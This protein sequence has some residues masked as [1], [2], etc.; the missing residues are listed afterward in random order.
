MVRDQILSRGIRDD[1]VLAAMR[2]VPR[3]RFVPAEYV[4]SAYD[5]CALAIEHLQT[6]S[7][8]FIVAYMTNA[9]RVERNHKVLEIGMGSGY[10]TAILAHFTDQL[11]TVERIEALAKVAC[12]RLAALGIPLPHIRTGDGSVGWPEDAPYDRIIVTAA[13]PAVPLA[14]LD[15][16]VDGGRMVIPVGGAERQRLVSVW[17][18][19][20]CTLERPM[21]PCRFVKLIGEGGW[22]A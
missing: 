16:L 21:I 14:L 6:I 20:G 18:R 7:Q 5:D 11:Y 4:E 17:K 13:A 3:E 19:R 9:L 15:Q 1:R 8:P 22:K 2:T 10:Q 12:D